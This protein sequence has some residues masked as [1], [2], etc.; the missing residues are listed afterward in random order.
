MRG[1]ISDAKKGKEIMDK[2]VDKIYSITI[3]FKEVNEQETN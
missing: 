1:W 3:F 2:T